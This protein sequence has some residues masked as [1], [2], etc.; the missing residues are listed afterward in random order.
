MESE[1]WQLCLKL[2]EIVEFIC[3]PKIHQNEVAYIKVLLEEYVYLRNSMFPDHPLKPK[4]HYLLH[5][6]DLILKFGPLIRLWTLRFESKHSF[7]KECARKLH[8]FLHLS[9]TL[10]ERHQ[11]LQSYLSCVQLFPPP[12]QVAGEAN[13]I[14]EQTYNEDIQM[15]LL[16][17]ASVQHLGPPYCLLASLS[18]FFILG[19]DAECIQEI[20]RVLPELDN[21]RLMGLIEHLTSAV[22]VT[23][24][25][26]LAFI[27]RDDF[28]DHLTPIQCRKVIQAFK[29]RAESGVFISWT[30]LKHS[31]ITHGSA[32]SRFLGT[33]CLLHNT[34]QA[35][36]RGHRANPADRRA[37]VRTV[38]A[39]MQKHCPNPNRA[40]C[41]EIAKLIVSKYPLTF[42]DTNEE[43]EQ[44]GIGY[45]SLVNQLKTRVEHVNR[46]NVSERIRRTRTTTELS[47][48]TKTVRC[49]VDSYGC[50]NWQ[51]KCLPEGETVDSLEDRRK[52]M[53]T[54][55]Q[56]AGPRVVDI[57]DI[58]NSMR[59][60]YIYQRHMI[61]SCPPPSTNE[62]E[63]QWPFLFT[64]RGLLGQALQTKG[65]RNIDFFQRQTQNKDIQCLLRDIES[66]TATMQHS[67]TS[68]AAVL[69]LMK[70]FLEKEDSIFIL[71]DVT[72]TK[73]S[74]EKDMSLP[75]TPRLIMLGNTF[76]SST[77]WMVSIEGKVAYVLDEHLGFADALSVFFS[78]NVFNIEYQ[79]TACATWV[80]LVLYSDIRTS[81]INN[82]VNMHLKKPLSVNYHYRP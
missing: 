78:C 82:F 28:Q 34:S 6:P 16:S 62:I 42:A 11:L 32:S 57:P 21:E 68:I 38:V 46:N 19:M 15:L 17:T 77:K 14:D 74:I 61:N 9:K 75:A 58:D 36:L 63:E 56:S 39:A 53:V 23:N 48:T 79:E 31:A 3:A 20:S 27:E 64:K 47:T 52:N 51:P 55:F 26:D 67:R 25:E 65:K 2:K 18:V 7:F 80:K 33:R 35:I 50:T 1:V 45:Y 72:A 60:T 69:L 24:K 43:G 49:K 73:A 22:G 4:H 70:H 66:D 81:A 30:N 10:A 40:A 37:M 71:A 41:V 12:I 76:L 59:L 5:Y 29:Q 54:I 8:N 13:E 44:L